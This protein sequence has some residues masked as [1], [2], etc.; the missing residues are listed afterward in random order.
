MGHDFLGSS[1][2]KFPENFREQ[3]NIWKGS[4]A[5]PGRNIPNG[6]SCTICSKPSRSS[7]GNWNWFVQMINAIPG[8]NLPVLNFAYHLPRSWTD[9]FALVDID[10]LGF[11]KSDMDLW[12][13]A[14]L[15][16]L[17]EIFQKVSRIFSK[18]CSKNNQKLLEKTKTFL[19]LMLK[20]ANFTTNYPRKISKH[21][22]KFCGVTSVAK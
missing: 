12:T 1:I 8:W 9:A 2:G 20:Y 3:R 13:R 22:V 5:F 15:H 14:P 10:G 4:P 6:I 18:S 7:F 19:D 17:L 16:K 21:F 11:E